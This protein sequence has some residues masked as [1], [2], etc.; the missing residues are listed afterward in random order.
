LALNHIR[1]AFEAVVVSC[2]S[3][4]AKV[5]IYHPSPL[6]REAEDLAEWVG[7]LRASQQVSLSLPWYLVGP[8]PQLNERELQSVYHC[9]LRLRA[10]YGW[11]PGY[12][13]NEY[14]TCDYTH[15]RTLANFGL[16]VPTIWNIH[17]ENMESIWGLIDRSQ[18]ANYSGGFSVQPVFQDPYFDLG[19]DSP[20]P[21]SPD[22][23]VEFLGEVY[24][25]YP[26]NDN[27]M[28]LLRD[29]AILCARGGWNSRLQG[30]SQVRL[31]FHPDGVVTTY[32]HIPQLG[33]PLVTADGINSVTSIPACRYIL[34][35]LWRKQPLYDTDY[36][37]DCLWLKVCGGIDRVH[38]QEPSTARNYQNVVCAYRQVFL[39]LFTELRSRH[40]GSWSSS[41]PE[42]VEAVA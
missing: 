41:L 5:V 23:F 12:S 6:L 22:A 16:V 7:S 11:R 36:C 19:H 27:T 32:R 18:Q 26:E 30:P 20:S 37:S 38:I 25:R 24:I 2:R 35:G 28:H 33:V 42:P 3:V 17:V 40:E 34:D 1:R 15:L 9:G 29:V 14:T 39:E 10:T 13:I 31:L 21:P 8:C 4:P